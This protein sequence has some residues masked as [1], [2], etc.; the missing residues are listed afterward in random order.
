MLMRLRARLAD[1]G[2][3]TLVELLVVIVLMSV[4]GGAM[5]RGMVSGMKAT[6]ATQGR[7]EALGE[8]QKSVDRMTRELRAAEPLVAHSTGNTVV[9]DTYRGDLASPSG[10]R[11]TIRYCPT[12]KKIVMRREATSVAYAAITCSTTTAPVLIDN[13]TYAAGESLFKFYTQNGITA[14]DPPAP[15]GTGR[16]RDV[17]VIVVSVRRTLPGQTDSIFVQTRVRLRNARA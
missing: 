11:Y 16:A 9:V 17:S 6:V 13:V 2:G 8:L 1:E 15:A 7:F 12:E 14:V 4:V 10:W 5:A 3:V